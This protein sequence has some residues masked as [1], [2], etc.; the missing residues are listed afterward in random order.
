[1]SSTQMGFGIKKL[2]NIIIGTF[3]NLFGLEDK[4]ANERIKICN[5]CSS[6]MYYKGFAICEECGC[7]LN[8]KVRVQDE[9]CLINKW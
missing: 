2:K 1:M 4:L 8:S 7:I 3:R 5:T 6:K 9:K